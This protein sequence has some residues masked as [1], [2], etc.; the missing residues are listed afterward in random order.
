VFQIVSADTWTDHLHKMINSTECV[1]PIVY[2]FCIHMLGTYYLMN[3]LLV[4]I[5]ENY[6][7]Q[8]EIY[9]CDEIERQIYQI[10][11]LEAAPESERYKK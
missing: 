4:V 7:E 5:M 10:K 9:A 3:L 1:I 11:K 6:I 2:V 8:E